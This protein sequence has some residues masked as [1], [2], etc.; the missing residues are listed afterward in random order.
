[1]YSIVS[2]RCIE[3]VVF[4][5]SSPQTREPPH[6]G[7]SEKTHTCVDVVIRNSKR[8]LE[9]QQQ[10]KQHSGAERGEGILSIILLL[11]FPFPL[12]ILSRVSSSPIILWKGS[13]RVSAYVSYS[14]L[15]MTTNKWRITHWLFLDFDTNYS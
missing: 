9:G 2:K 7:L 5:S 1:M 10:P 6:A 15:V 12:Q 8:G 14:R 4:P 11:S 13:R 3:S